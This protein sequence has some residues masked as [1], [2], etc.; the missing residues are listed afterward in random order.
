MHPAG[1][2]KDYKFGSKNNWRR[3]MWNEVLRR[4]DG[5][6]KREVIL[7]LA[8]PNDLDRTVAVSKGVPTQNLIAVDFDRRNVDEVRRDGVPAVYADVLDV[9]WSWPESRPVCAVILDYHNGFAFTNAAVYDAFERRP[10]RD[11]VMMVNFQRGRDAWSNSLRTGI[12][13]L[14]LM[15]LYDVD[16]KHRAASFLLHHLWQ[17]VS[18]SLLQKNIFDDGGV[19]LAMPNTPERK[20]AFLHLIGMLSDRLDPKFWSYKS[21]SGNLVF[22]SVVCW[23]HF[24]SLTARMTRLGCPTEIVTAMM[25]HT[26]DEV[27]TR[28]SQWAVPAVT[29]QI[30]AVLATRTK[31][32]AK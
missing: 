20:V 12:I 30:A 9:L 29:R 21:D 27:A 15:D 32:L 14:G 17:I 18:M 10:L 1:S 2:E 8:G 11:A 5:R 4:T 3:S 6:E 13:E 23:H 19:V 22:D 28:S 7:Y 25:R 31:R 16:E 24:H 26:D